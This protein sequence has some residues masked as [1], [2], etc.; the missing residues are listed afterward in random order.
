[1]VLALAAL[2]CAAVAFNFVTNPFGAWH[3]QLVGDV[4]YRLRGGGAERVIT[5]YRLRTTYPDTLLVGTSRVL[6]GMPIDQGY[7]DGFLNA[8]LSG[9]RLP[10]IKRA[11]RV[12]LGNPRLKRIIWGVDFFTFDKRLGCDPDTCARLDGNLRLMIVDNLLSSEALDSGFSLL[13][14]AIAGRTHLNSKAL[15]PIPWP[16]NLICRRFQTQAAI[17]LVNVGPNGTLRQILSESPLYRDTICCDEGMALFRS[18][19]DEIKRAGVQLIL[20]LPPMTQYELEEIRQNGLW[21]RFQQFKRDL[22]RS[23]PYWDFSGYNELAR[24]DTMFLDVVH[25]KPEVGMT[26]LRM[27]IGRPDSQCR[28]MQIVL[29]SGLW[30]DAHNISQVLALQDNRERAANMEPNK[31]AQVVARALASPVTTS[32]SP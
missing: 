23:A 15:E 5:P 24:T 32:S 6:F 4:Y 31:Y 11:V 7:K 10:E 16:A 19:V 25:M 30:V 8:A 3:H 20:F 27:L 29:G 12:G 17:G 26:I 2:T 22:T 21:P 18:I 28:D 14:R 13:R 1:M 9:A